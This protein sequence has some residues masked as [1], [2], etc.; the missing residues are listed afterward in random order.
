MTFGYKI[1]YLSDNI[2][3]VAVNIF[4]K[5]PV[6]EKPIPVIVATGIKGGIKPKVN[7][8]RFVF[9]SNGFNRLDYVFSGLRCIIIICLVS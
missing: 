6:I 5:R 1:L 2:E 4:L 7:L 3:E 9:L 8:D